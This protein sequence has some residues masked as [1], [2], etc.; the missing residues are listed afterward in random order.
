MK[1]FEEL[2][3][4]EKLRERHTLIFTEDHKKEIDKADKDEE[5]TTTDDGAE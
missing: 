1:L 5:E 2:D 4:M 3:K